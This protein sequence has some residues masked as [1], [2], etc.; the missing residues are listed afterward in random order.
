MWGNLA[1]GSK[2]SNTPKVIPDTISPLVNLSASLSVSY[3]CRDGAFGT[4]F[5]LFSRSCGSLG[6]LAMVKGIGALR[7][8]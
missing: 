3:F 4:F 5:P 6:L 8:Q 1:K 2:K 7:K